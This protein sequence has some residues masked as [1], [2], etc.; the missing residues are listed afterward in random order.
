MLKEHCRGKARKKREK[1]SF[2]GMIV[3]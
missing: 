2:V 1:K 3:I